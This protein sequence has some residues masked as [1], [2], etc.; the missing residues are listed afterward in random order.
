MD[1][2][3]VVDGEDGI[4]LRDEHTDFR[5]A[6]DDAFRAICLERG[7]DAGEFAARFIAPDAEAKLVE[8]HAVDK[9]DVGFARDGIFVFG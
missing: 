7:N 9:L 1:D 4:L 5:A 8:N 3:G 6:E 2:G